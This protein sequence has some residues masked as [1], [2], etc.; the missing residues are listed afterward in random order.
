MN[1]STQDLGV[2]GWG[3]SS[4][5]DVRLVTDIQGNVTI[6]YFASLQTLLPQPFYLDRTFERQA[7]GLYQGQTGDKG[8]LTQ[9]E[10]LYRLRER[11][12][13]LISFR[14]DGQLDYVENVNGYRVTAG[15]TNA[16][17][18]N[19]T[20]SNGDKLTFSY[21]AQG[22]ISAVTDQT[23]QTATYTYDSTGQFLKGITD[24]RGTTNFIYFHPYDPTALTGI[25]YAD[26]SK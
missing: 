20:A 22:R 14:A 7:D 11:D 5:E 24:Q 21:N 26:G 4:L 16:H 15:Y 3:W 6:F 19:L 12:G 13:T 9:E 18:T 8:I 2:F 10:N 23:G 1:N 25:T 17:L